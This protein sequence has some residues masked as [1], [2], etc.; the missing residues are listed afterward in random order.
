M[1]TWNSCV[2]GRNA[3]VRF[4][5][6]FKTVGAADVGESDEQASLNYSLKISLKVTFHVAF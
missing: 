4:R 6:A 5:L 2:F 1:P 3:G